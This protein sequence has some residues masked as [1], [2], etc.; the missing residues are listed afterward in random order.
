MIKNLKLK[1][2]FIFF[3]WGIGNDISNQKITQVEALS[4]C[5]LIE[6]VMLAS[7]CYVIPRVG[8]LA[9]LHHTYMSDITFFAYQGD[10]GRK[11]G[12]EALMKYSLK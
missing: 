7:N 12:N 3:F 1:S 4:I 2:G 5:Q 10:V 9:S 6:N 11:R 8:A